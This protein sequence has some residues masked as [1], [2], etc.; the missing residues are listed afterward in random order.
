MTSQRVDLLNKIDFVWDARDAT[1]WERLNEL[2]EFV[3]VNGYGVVPPKT[4]HAAL[5]DWL[6]YQ[7]KLYR[8]KTK[9]KKVSLT[10]ERIAELRKLGFILDS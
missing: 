7:K 9:G 8:E 4:T 1:W 3:G 10:D 6:R 5:V 2:K